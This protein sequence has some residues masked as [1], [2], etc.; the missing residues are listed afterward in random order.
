MPAQVKLKIGRVK[1]GMRVARTIENKFGACLVKPGMILDDNLIN[2]L[3]KMGIT[4]VTVY[5]ES[6]EMIERNIKEFEEKYQENVGNIK[7]IFK[8]VN[9]GNSLEFDN[10]RKIADE[11][12]S[13]DTNRDIV[14]LLTRVRD[15]DEYTYTH[16]V[17]VG[18]LAMMF[19]RWLKLP[20]KE[21]KSLMYAGFLHDIGKAKVPI[22][23]LNKKGKL[24]GSEFNIIK[25]HTVY[26]YELVKDCKF[27][28]KKVALGVLLHHERNDGSGYPLGLTRDKI[29]LIAKVLAIVDTYDAMTSDRVYREHRPPFEVFKVLEENVN[30]YDISLSKIFM[31][32]MAKFYIGEKVRLTNGQTGEIVYVNPHHVSAP[33]V[34]VDNKYVDLYNSEIGIDDMLL[35]NNEIDP[36]FMEEQLSKGSG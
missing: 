13:V 25:K 21:I 10:I 2:K 35:K 32:E 5:K 31:N 12:A 6:D 28:S 14:G 16:S 34:K 18:L 29:P 11:V 19:G 8:D 30:S 26:G 9:R 24:T 22:E 4:E 17:N 20:E 23:I 33:I 15:V 36:D 1:P 3:S 7:G 27:I